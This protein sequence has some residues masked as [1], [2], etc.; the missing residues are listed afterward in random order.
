MSCFKNFH[1]MEG[2]FARKCLKRLG[3][4][5]LIACIVILVTLEVISAARRRSSTT[6]WPIRTC[7][8]ARSRSSG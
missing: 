5:L 7:C 1:L 3:L 8:A 2:S 6:R 4:A